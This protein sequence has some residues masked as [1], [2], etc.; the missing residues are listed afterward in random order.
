MFLMCSSYQFGIA[1]LVTKGMQGP[2]N[3]APILA[4]SVRSLSLS[5]SL[6]V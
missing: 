1:G 3:K 6:Y 2:H 5:L 4:R